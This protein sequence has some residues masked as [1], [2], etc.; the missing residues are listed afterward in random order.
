MQKILT[1]TAKCILYYMTL[2]VVA[3]AGFLTLGI[4]ITFLN[5]L[6]PLICVVIYYIFEKNLTY[7]EKLL[8]IIIAFLVVL[9]SI[10]MFS[11]IYDFS[12][13]GNAY[14]KQAIGLLK[15]GWNP[16]Y[17]TSYD[18][19]SL[20]RS[21][22][23]S[24]DG[25]LFWAEVYPKAT[26]YFSASIYYF[27]GNIEAG[28]CY[29]VLF[30][31]IAFCISFDY[32]MKLFGKKYKAIILALVIAANPIVLAQSGSYYLDGLV[33]SLLSMLIIIFIDEMNNKSKKIIKNKDIMAC[34]IIWG[35]NLKFS[36]ILF[37]VT[38]CVVFIIYKIYKEKRFDWNNFFFL[39]SLGIFS[40]V[41]IGYSPYITNLKR[42]KNIF[43]GFT[44][45]MNEEIIFENFGVD[46]LPIAVQFWVSIF[47]KMSSG[48]ISNLKEL[49]K[50]P[51]TIYRQEFDMYY[52][53]DARISGFGALFSGLFIV[54][55]IVLLI[56]I[57]LYKKYKISEQ[58]KFAIVL[59]VVS[60]VEM[61][62]IPLTSQARYI[63]Q[64]YLCIVLAMAV[65]WESPISA[66]WERTGKILNIFLVLIVVFNSIPW[67]IINTKRIQSGVIDTATFKSMMQECGENDKVYEI[68]YCNDT[69]NGLDYNLK[70]YNVKFNYNIDAQI[71]E[72]FQ[73][74]CN[75]MI[76]YR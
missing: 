60:I 6:L 66:L 34:L 23:L 2:V 35:C 75:Y 56:R 47:S 16:V 8:I 29:T 3:T 69:Y 37:V 7:K 11:N 64:L 61:M 17:F 67:I 1:E 55:V 12:V 41:I 26:W 42:Y 68:R 32:F 13:D 18:F 49:L 5:T 20:V 33:S 44:G 38:Y 58:L 4:P 22:Q 62:L 74:T 71:D 73:F 28:K 59:L 43:Y 21:S 72:T 50:L 9:I 45:L 52:V 39:G 46:N 76:R 40:T 70:D 54:S 15:E 48:N 30:A 36:V 51:F 65:L 24:S 14:H 57:L 53:T 63:P 27:A 10:M 31:F 19:N 25:P